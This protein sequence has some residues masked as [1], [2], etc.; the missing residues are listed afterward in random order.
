MM[1]S[2]TLPELIAATV[3]QL[4]Q[5]MRTVV[6]VKVGATVE[7]LP[8]GSNTRGWKWRDR[9]LGGSPGR[10][11]CNTGVM[12]RGRYHVDDIRA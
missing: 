9:N 6:P 4:S 3:A 12:N 1:E 5:K 2:V 7:L 8:R 10:A 11:S